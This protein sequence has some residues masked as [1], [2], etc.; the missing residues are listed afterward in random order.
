MMVR[1]GLVAKTTVAT[2][3]MLIVALVSLYAGCA[4]HHIRL[5]WSWR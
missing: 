4:S 5:F 1:N 2:A 3:V